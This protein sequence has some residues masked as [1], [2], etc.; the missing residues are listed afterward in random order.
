MFVEGLEVVR[1]PLAW[2][3]G[4]IEARSPLVRR[5]V[6]ALPLNS[7]LAPTPWLR[8]VLALPRPPLAPIMPL[9][10]VAGFVIRVPDEIHVH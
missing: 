10:S 6:L 1:E 3:Y 4:R 2:V 8:N 7:T 5:N 9:L